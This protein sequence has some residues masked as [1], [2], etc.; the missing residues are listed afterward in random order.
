[1]PFA[2]A[3]VRAPSLP[4]GERYGWNVFR[5]GESLNTGPKATLERVHL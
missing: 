3:S 1:M 2:V 4:I 5:K